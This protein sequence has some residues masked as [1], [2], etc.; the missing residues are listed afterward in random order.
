MQATAVEIEV[1]GQ[2][3]ECLMFRPI[4]RQVRGRF[5]M[6]RIGE[7]QAKVKAHEWLPIPSQRIGI[8]AAGDGYLSEPLHAPEHAA[9]REKIQ[10]LS[11]GKL[12]PPVQIF[13][14]VDIATWLFWMKRAVDSG[15]ARVVKGQLPEVI[16]G[17]VRKNFLTVES[18][19]PS[20]GEK[21]TTVLEGLTASFNRLADAILQSNQ[22]KK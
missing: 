17:K 21:L 13:P 8:N 9:L 4:Q 1:D 10:K 11:L 16:E 6:G 19:E 7:P 12:E 5:D 14:N 20:S 18:T 2:F 15:L 3:N 22:A